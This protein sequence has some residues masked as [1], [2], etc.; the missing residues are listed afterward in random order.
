MRTIARRGF[1]RTTMAHVAK[2]AGLSQGIVNFYFK[3]KEMLLYETLV[4]LADEYEAL[5][6]QALARAGD[7]PVAALNAIIETDLGVD[8]CSP[9]KVALWVAFWAE[10]RGRP[11]YRELCAKLESRYFDMVRNLCVRICQRGGYRNDDVDHV[12][13]G[14]NAMING[15]WIGL[16]IDPKA[17]DREQAKYSCRAYMAGFYRA[18][19]APYLDNAAGEGQRHTG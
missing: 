12:A 5:T 19:F 1:A 3:T 2:A 10:S 9:R 13:R 16:V 11:K 6:T 17:F 18:E 4:Y 7:D 15:L 14:L 8:A